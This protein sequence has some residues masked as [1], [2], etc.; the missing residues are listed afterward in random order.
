L[1]RQVDFDP[2]L[3]WTKISIFFGYFTRVVVPHYYDKFD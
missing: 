2:F 1:Q 3:I